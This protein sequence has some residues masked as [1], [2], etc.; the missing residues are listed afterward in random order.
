MG[1]IYKRKH[2]YVIS[3]SVKTFAWLGRHFPGLVYYIFTRFNLPGIT[4]PGE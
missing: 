1:A 2:E 4:K 3:V